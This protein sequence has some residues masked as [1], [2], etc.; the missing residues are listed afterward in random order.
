MNLNLNVYDTLQ[1]I[2]IFQSPWFMLFHLFTNQRI[3]IKNQMYSP[4]CTLSYAHLQT[5]IHSTKKLNADRHPYW[6]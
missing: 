5:C 1:L 2:Y 6:I 3:M 4:Q